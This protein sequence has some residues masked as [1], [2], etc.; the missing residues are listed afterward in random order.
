[1]TERPLRADARRNRARVLEVATEVFEKDGIDVPVEEI[2]KRAGLGVGTL[3]RHFPTK[4]ALFEAI[5][6]DRVERL[7]A[8]ATEMAGAEDPGQA[9]FEFF[10]T[11]ISK[12]VLNRALSEIL[13][14]EMGQ[15]VAGLAGGAKEDLR[16][17]Q[18]VLL[19]RAQRAGAVR[20][21]LT[22]DEVK[23]VVLGIVTAE[24][25]AGG[26]PGRLAGIMLQSL[27]A[28]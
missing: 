7:A 6:I 4:E 26:D 20:A 3:Y 10:T 28:G 21:D 12:V 22:G 2:A 24:R 5:I 15:D 27:R 8:E 17:A 23:A 13:A 14:T 9:F 11:M 19:E 25:Q 18:D 1:M 16:R